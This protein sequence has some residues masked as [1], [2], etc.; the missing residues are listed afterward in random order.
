MLNKDIVIHEIEKAFLD[1][2]L[3]NG[4]GLWEAQA[5][6]DYE[7]V[8]AQKL[9]RNKDEKENWQKFTISTL[10]RC[11]SSL[12]FFDA[13]GMRFHLPAFIIAS[14]NNI[15]ILDP[16]FHLT[17]LSSYSKKQLSSLNS[18]QRKAIITYLKWC[19]TDDDYEFEHS[20]IETAL[21]LY[22]EK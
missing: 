15:D 16:I 18:T 9:A 2:K 10:N 8:V 14:I 22:W 12:S 13:K 5:I 17:H 3:E 20:S 1:V 21:K 11:N 7:S 19:L 6:D 4:I